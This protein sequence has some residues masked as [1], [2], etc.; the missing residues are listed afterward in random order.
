[1]KSSFP[2]LSQRAVG[3]VFA[4]T[5]VIGLAAW[6]SGASAASATSD[7]EATIVTPIAIANTA[8]LRF[9]A[10]STTAS[11][12]TITLA[13]A[14]DARTVGGVAGLKLLG[15]SN[16]TGSAA[17]AAAFNVTGQGSLTYAIT[18]PTSA[19]TISTDGGGT[20]KDLTVGTFTSS[21]SNVGTLTS[22][23]QTLK[24]GATLTTTS[25]TQTTGAY[26]GSFSVSVEY[27]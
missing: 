16:G 7:A 22:G 10:F 2:R 24:V 18:L 6:S 19:I 21:P 1:M 11:G 14:D 5:L 26:L 15:T 23:A 27:N 20:G 12:Q 25:A 4:S 17:N 9:G 3:A 13:P 8:P